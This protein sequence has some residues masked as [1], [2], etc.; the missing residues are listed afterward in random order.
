MAGVDEPKSAWRSGEYWKRRAVEN[1]ARVLAL[2]GALLSQQQAADEAMRR[3][4]EA[5][6]DLAAAD[7]A[8]EQLAVVDDPS[9]CFREP[10]LHGIAIVAKR[11]L[12]RK[13]L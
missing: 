1:A 2:E 4:E 10:T 3:A 11:G 6:R 8:L 12:A 9:Q 13:R 5:R 7:E